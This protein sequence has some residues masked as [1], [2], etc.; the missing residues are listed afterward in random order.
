MKVSEIKTIAKNS[1][2][3]LEELISVLSNGEAT[4]Y[5]ENKPV[6]FNGTEIYFEEGRYATKTVKIKV[7]DADYKQFYTLYTN[8]TT[9]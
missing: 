9:Y 3:S 5:K 8:I 6:H 7:K 4:V 2:E 1:F